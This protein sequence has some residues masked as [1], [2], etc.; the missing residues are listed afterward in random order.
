MLSIRWKK[1]VH[2]VGVY[3][4]EYPDHW[5]NGQKDGARSGDSARPTAMMFGIWISIVAV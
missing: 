5:E 4:L 1:F 3:R 2:P